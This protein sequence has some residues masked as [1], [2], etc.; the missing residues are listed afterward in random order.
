MNDDVPIEVLSEYAEDFEQ[1]GCA[2]VQWESEQPRHAAR[3]QT[4]E[5]TGESGPRGV[6]II[7]GRSS[8]DDIPVADGNRPTNPAR[9]GCELS[10]TPSVPRITFTDPPLDQPSPN[11]RWN[12][13]ESDLGAHRV[14]LRQELR[15]T[16]QTE[17]TEQITAQQTVGATSPDAPAVRFSDLTDKQQR[18]KVL[19]REQ[20]VLAVLQREK[21]GATRR[22]ALLSVLA[23]PQFAGASRAAAYAWC[24]RYDETGIDGLVEQKRGRVGRRSFVQQIPAHLLEKARAA[25]CEHGTG[26]AAGRQNFARAVRTT[27][28]GH[29]ELPHQV[30]EHLHGEHASK[31]YVNAN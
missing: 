24:G 16:E 11:P 14:H 2:A 1:R 7:T 28:V 6:V 8:V 12:E 3:F 31:S 13:H 20:I 9:G 15:A 10:T 25:A 22:Q 18:S 19:W 23:Q 27:L 21:D 4:Q 30:A 17:P 29:P 5:P 26:G